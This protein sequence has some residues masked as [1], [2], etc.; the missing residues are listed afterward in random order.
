[1]FESCAKLSYAL[2]NP[3]IWKIYLFFQDGYMIKFSTEFSTGIH[4]QCKQIL[5]LASL[6][7]QLTGHGYV[8]AIKDCIA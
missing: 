3:F 2:F 6:H 5:M 1:M 7:H 8:I 4:T